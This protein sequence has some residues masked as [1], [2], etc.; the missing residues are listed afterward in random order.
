MRLIVIISSFPPFPEKEKNVIRPS[1]PNID[2][3]RRRGG[4]HP[5][6][7]GYP[8]PFPRFR[9][10]GFNPFA[11]SYGTRNN[12]CRPLLPPATPTAAATVGVAGFHSGSAYIPLHAHEILGAFAAVAGF[13]SE[14]NTIHSIIIIMKIQKIYFEYLRNEA[15][16]QFLLLVRKLFTNCP[17]VSAIA[18]HQLAG[19]YDLMAIEA[20]LVDAIK[21]SVYTE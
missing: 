11:S 15:H 6:L 19:L 18:A 4:I 17:Q 9:Q 3:V 2:N 8:V 5:Y 16:Y 10:E 12:T 21:G 13:I 7:S 14:T 1:V 20:S